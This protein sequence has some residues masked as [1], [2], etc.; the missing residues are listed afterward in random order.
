MKIDG[1]VV[2]IVY[3]DTKIITEKR[4]DTSSNTRSI[5]V[6]KLHKR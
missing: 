5:I 6:C 2:L 3:K 1:K 4:K